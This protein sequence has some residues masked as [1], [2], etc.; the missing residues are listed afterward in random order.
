[1]GKRKVPPISG[2]SQRNDYGEYIGRISGTLITM[3]QGN[4]INNEAKKHKRLKDRIDNT[5]NQIFKI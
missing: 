5:R 4:L 3:V 2:K 1:V